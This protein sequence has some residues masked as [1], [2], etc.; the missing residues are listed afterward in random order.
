M[1]VIGRHDLVERC[2]ADVKE[3]RSVVVVGAEGM[4]KSAVLQAL[5]TRLEDSRVA[6]FT[7]AGA[8]GEA[9]VPLAPFAGTLARLGIPAYT[10]LDAYTRLPRELD[11]VSGRLVID[12]IDQLDA[13]SKVLLDHVARAG[14]PVLSTATSMEALPHGL[15]DGIDSGSWVRHSLGPL[16]ADA[17]V[18]IAA[19]LLEADPS[20]TAAAALIARAEGS[21]RMLRDL[22][23]QA[24]DGA[25]VHAGGIELGPRLVTERSLRDWESTRA[26]LDPASVVLIEHLA[27]AGSL[28]LDVIA[29]ETL[30][31]LRQQ[32][33]VLEGEMVTLSSLHLVD[34]L[35]DSMSAALTTRRAGQVADL[36]AASATAPPECAVRMAARAGRILSATDAV[37]SAWAWL[38][39][40]DPESALAVASAT[41]SVED[42]VLLVT[43]AVLSALERL[44]EAEEAFSQ[45]RPAADGD[46][47]FRLCQEWGLLLAVRRGDPSGAVERVTAI[48]EAVTD[49][50]QRAVI[51][52]E[53]VK[54]RL[55]AGVPGAAPQD[56]TPEAGADLRVG[57][58][59]IQA[60]V[61]S[62]D[63]PPQAALAIVEHGKS[64]LAASTRPAR[65][66]EELLALS[67]FLATGFDARLNEAEEAAGLRRRDALVAGHSAVGLWE[68]ASGE[69]A[70]QAGRYGAA[71]SFARR[72]VVHLAWRDFTGLRATTVALYA[73][74][75]ARLGHL[76]VA[77]DA[78]ATLPA[79]AAGD[80][81]VA[82]HLARVAAEQRLQARDVSD[83][84]RLLR[85]AGARAVE[86]SHSQMGILVLDE[87]WMVS[88]AE[89]IADEVCE[90]REAGALAA[91]LC[92]RVVAARTEDVDELVAVADELGS[93]GFVGRSVHGLE[94][95]A[96]LLEGRGLPHD[97]RRLHARARASASFRQASHWPVRSEDESL[98]AREREIAALA[99]AR[100]RSKEVAARLGLSVRTV[101]NHLGNVFR[102]LGIQGRDELADAL[103]LADV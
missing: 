7:V 74:A 47:A 5:V 41:D 4:G 50:S 22:I 17:I 13:A 2:L 45:V 94:L 16:D 35:L 57:M 9:G 33:L 92:R 72:A 76:Q 100:V 19:E 20:V 81:K 46:V 64:A 68:F 60:M 55:M 75:A 40:E 11:A 34:A 39:K 24:R 21:P 62:L 84:V 6:V 51:D 58:A 52:G 93:L 38:A 69:L 30:T 36:L 77:T 32:G 67:E 43:G 65:H 86:E 12:D 1:T 96:A 97:A 8:D 63:G 83:A 103:A 49:A 80:V 18:Q 82:V 10:P 71:E 14:V 59:L 79:T 98:T 91:L 26:T 48:R 29:D 54:W 73:A 78:V 87:A 101:D 27:V 99:A 28:P 56:L 42:A 95:A 44:D 85:E 31:V 88:P 66:A 23:T 102:K 15:V 3:H 61:A 53:L 89:E 90:H 70:L 25:V 37:E